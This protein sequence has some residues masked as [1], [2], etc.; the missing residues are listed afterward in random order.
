M[1]QDLP[2]AVDTQIA[3]EQSRPILLF[4]LYLTAGTLRYSAT[5]I[6]IIFPTGGGGN[7]YYAKAVGMDNIKSSSDG[8]IETASFQFD[9]IAQDMWAYNVAESFD[10]NQ[11]IVK[12]VYRDALGNPTYY[13]ELFNGYMSE[14]SKVDKEWF[15]F[16]A[17]SGNKF[18]RRLLQKFF[19]K[20][21]NN[22]FGD[23]ACNADGLADLTSLTASGTAD[24]GTV[25]TL[26]DAALT[27]ADA[28]WQFGVIN[29]TI[30]GTTYRRFVES[31]VAATDTITFDVALPVAVTAT[32]TYTVYK[33]CPLTVN[34]CEANG[35]YGPSADNS[36]NFDGFIHIGDTPND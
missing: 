6:D 27:Q 1:A 32:S 9:N 14:P 5:N 33:G 31:F 13:R 22:V 3:A 11:I 34:A 16:E 36:A 24:S 10:G 23:A 17:T 18:Q 4:E 20:E 7:T 29:V 30:S 19:Q 21:C 12:K 35:A 2:A 8:Q 25:S 15:I 28:F 26:V